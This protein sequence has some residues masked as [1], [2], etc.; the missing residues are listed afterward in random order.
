MQATAV[1]TDHHA[2][3]SRLGDAIRS[4]DRHVAQQGGQV[5]CGRGREPQPGQPGAQH[6]TSPR[7]GQRLQCVEFDRSA[8]QDPREVVSDAGSLGFE[9]VAGVVGHPSCG[10]GDRRPALPQRG[11]DFEAQVV[12]VEATIQVRGVLLPA[13]ALRAGPCAEFVAREFEQRPRVP[14]RGAE[15]AER[16]HARDRAQPASA[17]PLQQDGL[18]LVVGVVGG[19]QH[20]TRFEPGRER[21]IASF[22]GCSL[23]TLARIQVDGDPDFV[24]GDAVRVRQL[25][26]RTRPL[27]GIGMQRMIDVDGPQSRG[28]T[29]R[30]CQL[31][32]RDE[33]DRGVEP[34]AQ[35]DTE[36][37]RVFRGRP[38]G[39]ERA[40]DRGL[41][42]VGGG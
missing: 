19:E 29:A 12:A 17:Q 23:R 8:G 30:V 40:R 3:P 31:R 25:T 18:E 6:G 39:P 22:A 32:Q 1:T 21:G 34:A 26:A 42:P 13:Q 28:E 38:P 10:R 4:R 41:S 37:W 5:A 2:R 20:L 11:Q 7:L 15:A 9:R 36:S 27:R 33:Q 14:C 16:R 35:C 24:A